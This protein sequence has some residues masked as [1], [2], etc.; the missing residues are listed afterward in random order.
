MSKNTRTQRKF[1]PIV[2]E[3]KDFQGKVVLDAEGRN[4]IE[5]TSPI[6]YRHQIQKF[7][8]GEVISIYMSSKRPKRSVQQNRF[9]WGVYL[10][11]I[12]KETG[13]H[14]LEALHVLFKGKFLTKELKEVMGQKVRLTKST[15][16]L[17]K[18]DFSEYIMNIES[19]TGITSPPTDGYYD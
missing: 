12:A 18:S 19:L 10:P 16:E 9:Y 2:V 6:W 14:D 5:M 4:K 11:L 15:A 17:S 13:E 1:A 3:T 8:V 7:K